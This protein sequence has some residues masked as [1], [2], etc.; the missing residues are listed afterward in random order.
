MPTV[1]EALEQGW[2]EPAPT[3]FTEDQMIWF[4][5]C[6]QSPWVLVRRTEPAP[7]VAPW[8][9]ERAAGRPEELDLIE[10]ARKAGVI[11]P[12]VMPISRPLT[13]MRLRDGSAVKTKG[14][15]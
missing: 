9:I 4:A 12:S 7:V 11:L 14:R 15:K 1:E 6:H 8:V 13:Y 5:K 10:R 3:F 2:Q